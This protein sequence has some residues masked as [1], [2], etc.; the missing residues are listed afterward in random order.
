[1]LCSQV[2]TETPLMKGLSLRHSNFILMHAG[3]PD[4][5]NGFAEGSLVD[6][7]SCLSAVSVF[8][9]M[10]VLF[11]MLKDSALVDVQSLVSCDRCK[12]VDLIFFRMAG[13]VS[14][15]SC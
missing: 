4:Q 10:Y 1:M 14:R 5:R 9:A 12:T 2:N 15:A 6:V 3:L 13:T 8:G 7:P 11:G